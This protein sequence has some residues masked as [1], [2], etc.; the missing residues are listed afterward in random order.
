MNHK[1]EMSRKSRQLIKFSD[2]EKFYKTVDN[3]VGAL[4]KILP[5]DT[6]LADAQA[7]LL[8][9]K[10]LSRRVILKSFVRYVYPY[11]KQIMKKDE[12]FFLGNSSKVKEDYLTKAL[13]L[14]EL[15]IEKLCP[16][17][18]EV[19]WT[20]FKV[21]VILSERAMTEISKHDG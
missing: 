10:T 8:L 9:V 16:Q 17:N 20:Y 1:E 6:A 21:L 3:F 7:D 12:S 15:W 19:V 2:E 5:Q 18:K 4:R 13:K 11:K 14:K